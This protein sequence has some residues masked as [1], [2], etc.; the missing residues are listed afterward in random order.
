MKVLR[1]AS[2]KAISSDNANKLCNVQRGSGTIVYEFNPTLGRSGFEDSI[3]GLSEK[4]KINKPQHMNVVYVSIFT[5]TYHKY[6]Y[7]PIKIRLI[8]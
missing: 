8:N 2:F 3:S 4:V 5:E 1:S 7:Q 6:W